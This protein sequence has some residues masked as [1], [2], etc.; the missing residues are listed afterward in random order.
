MYTC[1]PPRCEHAHI[2]ISEALSSQ[3]LSRHRRDHTH[4]QYVLTHTHTHRGLHREQNYVFTKPPSSS[5]T[6][7]LSLSVHGGDVTGPC[8][9][10]RH[11]QRK[12]REKKKHWI[13]WSLSVCAR[14]CVCDHPDDIHTQRE[15]YVFV[16]LALK[17]HWL[18]KECVFS[19][20]GLSGFHPRHNKQTCTISNTPKE[21]HS[22]ARRDTRH[23]HWELTLY[24][25]LYILSWQRTST[26]NG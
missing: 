19:T 25:D 11:G 10:A 17:F 15:K 5:H 14:V 12:W 1:T 20:F 16:V 2:C 9:Q 21:R 22:L 3:A 6:I 24:G 7:H 13:C 8:K 23:C 26:H 18:I 4:V